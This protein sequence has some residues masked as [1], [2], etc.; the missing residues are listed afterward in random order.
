MS[1]NWIRIIP[2]DPAFVPTAR[3]GTLGRELL[4]QLAPA[5][6]GGAAAREIDFG[7]IVFVDAGSN[8]NSAAC[9]W[10]GAVVDLDWWRE[11]M[12][13]AALA[14]FTDL[15]TR[16]RCCDV[17]TSLNDLRYDWPQ[18]F[19]RWILEVMNPNNHALSNAGLASIGNTIGI[20][21]RAIYVR[22]R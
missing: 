14:G 5:G 21:V 18:G 12:D 6:A 19:A 20:A 15:L 8:F 17:T 11:R 2:T 22:C 7:A 10:C 4:D 16:T 1:D 13:V 9:P 3:A